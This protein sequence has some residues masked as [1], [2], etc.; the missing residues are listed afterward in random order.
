MM[1]NEWKSLV[2]AAVDAVWVSG[3]VCSGF[4]ALG[5]GYGSPG[6]MAIAWI[7]IWTW[8]GFGFLGHGIGDRAFRAE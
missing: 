5:L 1:V 4:I 2:V 7:W 8:V 3:V 6:N